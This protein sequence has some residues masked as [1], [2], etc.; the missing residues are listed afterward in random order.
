M[1]EG[2][3]KTLRYMTFLAG[4]ADE[5]VEVI[6]D[7]FGDAGGGHHDHLGIV[8]FGGIGEPLMDVLLAAEHRRILGH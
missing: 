4:V 2:D 6:A 1:G 5:G 8:E 3:G 7:D